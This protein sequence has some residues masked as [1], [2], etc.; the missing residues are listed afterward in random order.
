MI[1]NLKKNEREY[2]WQFEN[3]PNVI[4]F[5]DSE[6]SGIFKQ[7]TIRET[8]YANECD[9][10]QIA[11]TSQFSL[12]YSLSGARKKLNRYFADNI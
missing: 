12:G 6:G 5:T 10:K 3:E 11:G 8:N 2:Q 7:K 1:K 9:T 4:Y